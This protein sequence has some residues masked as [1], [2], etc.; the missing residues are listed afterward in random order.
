MFG[1]SV[2]S[3]LSLCAYFRLVY[4]F[5]VLAALGLRGFARALSSCGARGS[6]HGS[7]W[8]SHRAGSSRSGAW[9]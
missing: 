6:L 4:S 7:A 8:A 1:P 3:G 2:S 9:L 5:N